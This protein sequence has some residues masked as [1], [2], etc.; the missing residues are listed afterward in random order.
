MGSNSFDIDSNT[1]EAV[2][3]VALAIAY[4]DDSLQTDERDKVLA[5]F[6]NICERLGNDEEAS[7]CEDSDALADQ[8]IEELIEASD[9]ESC[10]PICKGVL[11]LLPTKIS[12]N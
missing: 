1:A 9:L 2:L 3:R 8:I 7:L 10:L 12:V 5:S 11:P 6:T 4:S